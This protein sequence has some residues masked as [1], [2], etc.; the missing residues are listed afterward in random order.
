MSCLMDGLRPTYCRFS[1]WSSMNT[2]TPS[3][4]HS[5]P[6]SAL[7]EQKCT[8]FFRKP[9][10]VQKLWWFIQSSDFREISQPALDTMW[11]WGAPNTFT[12][13]S[14]ASIIWG[15]AGVSRKLSLKKLVSSP[16]P[17]ETMTPPKSIAIEGSV[18]GDLE[19]KFRHQHYTT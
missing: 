2:D 10:R 9:V 16:F 5:G 7:V 18:L 11:H 13:L 12:I 17:A 6:F 3:F 15:V 14:T 8:F 4:A 19:N 1:S